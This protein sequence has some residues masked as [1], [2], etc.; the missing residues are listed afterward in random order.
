M[1]S[2]GCEPNMQKRSLVRL[3]ARA[4]TNQWRHWRAASQNPA[5]KF[6]S[7]NFEWRR[8][9]SEGVNETFFSDEKE[10]LRLDLAKKFWQM[11]R[12]TRKILFSEEKEQET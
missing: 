3:A 7:K 2:S 5:L 1:F 6:C 12:M 11:N 4:R 9:F 10:K 8:F